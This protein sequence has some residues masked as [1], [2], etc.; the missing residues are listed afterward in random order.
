MDCADRHPILLIWFFIGLIQLGLFMVT[1]RQA[2][3]YRTLRDQSHLF[4]NL[5][6]LR[7]SLRA[8]LV[9]QPARVSLDSVLTDEEPVGNFAVAHSLG[10]QFQYFQFTFGYSKVTLSGFVHHEA[11]Q[12]RN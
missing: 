6:S 2:K 4:P 12:G 9:K 7:S 8:K 11:F 5:N 1:I 10:N 3:A